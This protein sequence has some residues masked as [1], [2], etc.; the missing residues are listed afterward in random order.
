MNKFFNVER[1]EILRNN[2]ASLVRQ[3]EIAKEAYKAGKISILELYKKSSIERLAHRVDFS[4]IM[5]V[6][7]NG[8]IESGKLIRIDGNWDYKCT[9]SYQGNAT[10]KTYKTRYYLYDSTNVVVQMAWD[11]YDWDPEK[12]TKLFD[13]ELIHILLDS[14]KAGKRREFV[15]FLKWILSVRYTGLKL[16]DVIY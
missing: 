12:I 3:T 10:I 2:Q 1:N 15:R 8:K 13:V 14:L 7:K 5:N 16:E 4:G 9:I 6:S 11:R